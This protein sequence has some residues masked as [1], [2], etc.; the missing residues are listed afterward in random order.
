M[1]DAVRI[2]TEGLL[3]TAGLAA[4][5]D[6]TLGLAAVSPST[7]TIAGP[8]GTADVEPRVMQVLVVLADGAGQVVTRETL[9]HR[10]W[11]GVYVGD[12]SLNRAIGAVR[13]LAAE[14]ADGSF[15]IETIPR[16]GYRLNG[17]ISGAIGIGSPLPAARL[18]RRALIGSAAAA[19]AVI[20]GTGLWW[21][22]RQSDTRFDA[23]IARGSD[24]MHKGAWD[25]ET[26]EF[27][28]KAL[29]LRPGS[30]MAWG[31]L[32]LLKSGLAQ[33]V[34]ETN[35]SAAVDQAQ[36]AA[37]RA[38]AIDPLEP[39]ALLAMLALQGSALDWATRDRKL[40]QII[41][42]DPA[43]TFAI[44][45]L[46]L[47]LQAAGLN[48]ESWS[49]NERALALEPLS[50]EYLSKRALK[51]WIDGRTSEADKVIDQA[52][53]L[54][55]R[56]PGPWWVRF[57]ILAL[58]GRPQAARA[59]LDP[60]P[61]RL[62]PAEEVALW[63]A[64]LDAFDQPTPANIARTR[65]ACF[66]TAESP[67]GDVAECVMILSGLGQVD[68]AFDVTNGFLLSRGRVVRRDQ[69]A[70]ATDTTDA[71]RRINT[72]WLFTPPCAVMRSDARFLPLCEAL[73]LTAY[74]RARHVRPDYQVYA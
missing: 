35:G 69:P 13:K 67:G 39:N 51:L 19:T 74:W 5:P 62:G 41:A 18:S 27:F 25:A 49:W 36:S 65:D 31:Y 32:A 48:R 37:R 11:G 63:R 55:P 53:S 8:G 14:I 57:L 4:R 40:R 56:D 60:N 17:Q 59:M 47:L 64:S 33:A 24:A 16:T 30:A 15:E 28:N 10:C 23:L 12:D 46:V 1:N 52:R 3:T 26:A 68:S 45:E 38:L 34:T 2:T 54:Y 43:N 58:T 73:G 42:I 61:A 20:G 29:A 50:V 9:F 72:Q 21:V 6:F 22:N 71:A 7:R 66:R 44:A 70:P